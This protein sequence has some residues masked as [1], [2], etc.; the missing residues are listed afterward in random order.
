MTTVPSPV[1]MGREWPNASTS[2]FVD[3]DGIRWHVQ[4]M[5]SGPA[6]VLL[7][8]TGATCHSWEGLASELSTEFA[9]TIIDLPGHGFTQPVPRTRMTLPSI[10]RLVSDLLRSLHVAPAIIVGHSAGAAIAIR[11]ALDGLAAPAL[12]VSVNGA[13]LPWRGGGRW[14]FPTLARAMASSGL[15]AHVLS[16]RADR[17]GVVE[18]LL[19]G[20]GR[21]PPKRSVEFY[22]AALRRSSQVQAALDMM[23]MWDLEGLERDLPK[24]E[25]RLLLIAAGEDRAVP[26]DAAFA[27]SAKVPNAEVC[28]L[29][30]LGHLAHEE[31]PKQVAAAVRAAL[32][33][34]PD[35]VSHAEVASRRS[36]AP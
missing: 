21:L 4:R 11:M 6:M 7:H 27:V 20:T 2:V 10:A 17:P 32:L 3:V 26:A 8:G 15:L 23:A 9:L 34:R 19:E 12:I 5:G 30:G 16:R 14:L 29:R 35:P 22:R 28:Y 18:R 36:G 25:T 31:S 33:Q 13:L 1:L 24:L